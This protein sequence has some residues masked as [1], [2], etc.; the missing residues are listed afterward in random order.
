MTTIHSLRRVCVLS[1]VVALGFA[2]C[3]SSPWEGAYTG[4]RD[5]DAA[6]R[7]SRGE[8]AP[9][10]VRQ[11]PW[12]RV[13]ETLDAI[14][15]DVAASDVHP[16]EWTPQR[17]LE[18]KAKLLKGLQVSESPESVQVLGRS[19]FRTTD[20]IAPETEEGRAELER[21]AQSV[22]ADMVVWSG[23][24]LGKTE[25]VVKEPITTYSSGSRSNW[26]RADRTTP[27]IFSE[28]ETT[29]VPVRVQ[30][31]ELG[32]IAYFLKLDGGGR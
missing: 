1:L 8:A 9:V 24:Y 10:R 13:R 30:M 3:Q 28:T 27:G 31:D 21:F 26:T 16:D 6:E 5:P 23:Q 20:R 7:A 29:W 19:E 12:G 18:A 14:E 32:Y 22:G 4:L 11:V 15:K 2:G 17:K 25:R